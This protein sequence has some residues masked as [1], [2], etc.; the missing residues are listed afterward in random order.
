MRSLWFLATYRTCGTGISCDKD[1]RAVSLGEDIPL[2]CD[3]YQTQSVDISMVIFNN[4]QLPALNL[5]V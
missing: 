4:T 3:G 2:A 5:Y 1:G